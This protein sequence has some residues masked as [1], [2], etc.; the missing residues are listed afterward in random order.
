MGKLQE[1]E[2]SKP[3]NV[4][5]LQ[6]IQEGIKVVAAVIAVAKEEHRKC[7]SQG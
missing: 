1:A 2:K 7:Y 5:E 6:V 4:A 3:E